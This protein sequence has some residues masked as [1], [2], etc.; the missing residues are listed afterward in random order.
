MMSGE[1]RE[2]LMRDM[3][4]MRR[5]LQ[6]QRRELRLEMR[7][8]R[9]E[10]RD[11]VDQLRRDVEQRQR[12]LEK[13]RERIGDDSTG[14]HDALNEARR[15]LELAQAELKKARSMKLSRIDAGDVYGVTVAPTEDAVALALSPRG[16]KQ[17][18]IIVMAESD[19][20][21]SAYVDGAAPQIE[22]RRIVR[23]QGCGD[24]SSAPFAAFYGYGFDE[25]KSLSPTDSIAGLRIE[26]DRIVVLGKDN[27]VSAT[28]DGVNNQVRVFVRRNGEGN[29]KTTERII[30]IDS[31]AP[32][33]AEPPT[34]PQAFAR[35]PTPPASPRMDVNAGYAL[36]ENRP[37]PFDQSTTIS[38]TLGKP[39]H[40]LLT[41]FD[42][43]GKVVRTLV[44][45]ELA[46][47]EHTVTLQ[48][49]DLPNGLYLYRLSSGGYS[50]TRTMT[51]QK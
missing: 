33:V 35:T 9:R 49:D 37:N 17:R 23:R 50:E 10:L 20:A 42:A 46:A 40:A 11:D 8:R 14:L 21:A 48:S 4:E 3:E 28:V 26:E 5:D 12:E 27:H 47:G 38:F 29:E 30:I 25:L 45:E 22:R 16:E 43:T 36:S 32:A 1:D 24:S 18:R 19:G 13:L 15:S 34:P 6:E 7:E 2:E 41:V 31:D 39:G 44:D 51:L